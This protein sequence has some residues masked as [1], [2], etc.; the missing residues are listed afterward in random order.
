MITSRSGHLISFRIISILG[1]HSKNAFADIC[2]KLSSK[3]TPYD[4]DKIPIHILGS[5]YER[6]LGK[7]ITTSAK[8]AKVEDKPEVKKAGGVFY[9]PEYIVRYIVENTIGKL[10]KDKTPEEISKMPFA[11]IACG[12][13][14]FLLG[15]YDSLLRY[16]ANYYN[17][18]PKEATPRDRSKRTALLSLVCIKSGK[19]CS[20]IFTAWI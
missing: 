8:R 13:G 14:S 2:E 16:H 17:K 19:Y 15:A 9:T 10:T 6:F 20:I 18:N 7:V 1:A 12:S 11:D 3:N 4:F 5:I